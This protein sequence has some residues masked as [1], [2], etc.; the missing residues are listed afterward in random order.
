MLVK[1]DY[2]SAIFFI[3]ILPEENNDT[4]K[5]GNYEKLKI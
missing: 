1:Q 2:T 4:S 5:L 3:L